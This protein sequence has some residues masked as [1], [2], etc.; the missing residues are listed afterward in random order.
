M[1]SMGLMWILLVAI[2]AALVWF[3]LRASGFSSPVGRGGAASESPEAILKKRY[4]R[5]EIGQ[6]EYERMLADLKR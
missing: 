5:G 1:G 3:F 4:A 6:E 2:I